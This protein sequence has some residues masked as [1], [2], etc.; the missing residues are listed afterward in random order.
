MLPNET[1][2]LL[3]I[4]SICYL[5]VVDVPG[6]LGD[7]L[8]APGLADEHDV[9]ALVVGT[10]H[11]V[12]F[13]LPLCLRPGRTPR[14]QADVGVAG[15]GQGGQL[16]Q[17]HHGAVLADVQEGDLAL[18]LPLVSGLHRGDGQG[19]L[20]IVQGQAASTEQLALGL[21]QRVSNFL[22]EF[23]LFQSRRLKTFPTF[24]FK[25]WKTI[26]NGKDTNTH[27]QQPFTIKFSVQSFGVRSFIRGHHLIWLTPLCYPMVQCSMPVHHKCMERV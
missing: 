3:S 5:L 4:S 17:L 18:V 12:G 8:P 9:S 19:R 13:H 10:H 2:E 11:A 20:L 6:D 1:N 7:G 16:D 27:Q 22:S 24:I 15:R 23:L 21:E 26:N 14:G 25:Y